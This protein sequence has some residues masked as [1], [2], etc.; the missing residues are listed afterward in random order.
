[1][2]TIE[3]LSADLSS[4]LPLPFADAG[5]KAGFPSPAQDYLEAIDPIESPI[6]DA[7]VAM[8]RRVGRAH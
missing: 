8:I 3:L 5:I 7:V 4:E 2:L 1:M 6:D